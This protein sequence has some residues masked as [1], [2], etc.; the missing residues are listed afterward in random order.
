[1]P[2]GDA[3][4]PLA[5]QAPTAGC[6]RL[7]ADESLRSGSKNLNLRLCASSNRYARELFVSLRLNGDA[8]FALTQVGGGG[9]IYGDRIAY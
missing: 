5:A 9:V 3:V 8:Y 7:G 1:M 4:W 2:R 6:R